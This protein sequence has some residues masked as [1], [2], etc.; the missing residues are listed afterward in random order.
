MNVST[1]QTKTVELPAPGYPMLT[2][3]ISNALFS[4]KGKEEVWVV[5]GPHPLVPDLKVIRMFNDHGGVEIYSVT[6][7]GKA[8]TRNFVPM[9]WVR[10]TE[11]AMPIDVFVEELAAAENDGGDDDEPEEPEE[12][13]STVV[14]NGQPAS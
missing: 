7:D 6:A 5:G 12:S 14:S 2:R 11:E 4:E 9:H 10:L 1:Q 3:M 8:G 13:S